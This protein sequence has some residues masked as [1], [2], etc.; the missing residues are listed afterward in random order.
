MKLAQSCPALWDPM[1][2]KPTRLLCPWNFQSR[3]LERVAISFFRGSSGPRDWTQVYCIGGRLFAIWATRV[4]RMV[5]AGLLDPEKLI[6]LP[7]VVFLVPSQY[8]FLLQAAAPKSCLG[9][10]SF[11]AIK[12][13]WP[14]WGSTNSLGWSKDS[15]VSKPEGG[16]PW[17]QKLAEGWGSNQSEC[18][19]GL[20]QQSPEKGLVLSQ[21]LNKWGYNHLASERGDMKA[22]WP[23]VEPNDEAK[24]DRRGYW[25]FESTLAFL[26]CNPRGSF[27]LSHLGC[28]CASLCVLAYT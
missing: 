6:K 4:V 16:N 26:F 18:I 2:C 13:V 27:G 10:T 1:A 24:T 5:R 7:P 8:P 20:G 25:S 17:P 3:I 23:T 21:Q 22:P 15:G 28:V 14:K 11:L 19:S 9:A 12:P